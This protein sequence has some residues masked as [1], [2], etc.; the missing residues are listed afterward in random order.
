MRPNS[1]SNRDQQP[2]LVKVSSPKLSE[3][4]RLESVVDAKSHENAQLRARLGHNAKG[5]EALA[6]TVNQYAKKVRKNSFFRHVTYLKK[7]HFEY[8]LG[9]SL[10]TFCNVVLMT[11]KLQI[12]HR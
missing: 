1:G 8:Y 9:F 7:V 11:L 2:D 3:L 5:F 12:V 10:S 4:A 6:I